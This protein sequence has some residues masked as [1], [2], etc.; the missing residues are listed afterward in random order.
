MGFSDP[1]GYPCDKTAPIPY[2]DASPAKT[3][4]FFRHNVLAVTRML[5]IS[6]ILE[7]QPLV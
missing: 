4:G 3:S 1:S 6:L 7:M 5:A 2:A